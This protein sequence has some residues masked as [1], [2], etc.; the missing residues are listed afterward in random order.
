MDGIE[1]IPE[2]VLTALRSVV[3]REREKKHAPV[4]RI[5]VALYGL[6][7]TDRAAAAWLRLNRKRFTEAIH[8][9]YQSA[10]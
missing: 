5:S 1:P 4:S 7:R 8:L 2:S 3:A 10:T 9:A 6:E